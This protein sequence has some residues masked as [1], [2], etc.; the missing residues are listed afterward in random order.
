MFPFSPGVYGREVIRDVTTT[1]QVGFTGGAVITAKKGPLAPTRVTER[2]F[3]NLY[4]KPSMDTPSMLAV[5]R[6]LRR[7]GSSAVIKRVIVDATP[8]IGEIENDDDSIFLTIKAANPGVWG[9]GISITFDKDEDV[10]G[11]YT[12]VVKYNSEE[13]ERY[14]VSFNENDVD[15]FGQ[16]RYIESR[17]NGRSRYIEVEHSGENVP[18]FA[19]EGLEVLALDGGTDDT[20]PVSDVEVIAGLDEFRNKEQIQIDYLMNAG[21][22]SAAVHAAIV[23]VAEHRK[24]CVAV[25]D[26]PNDTDV[27]SLV[28]FRKV[29]SNIN[30]S[31]AAYYAGWLK[32]IDPTSGREVE[33]PPSGDVA[34]VYARSQQDAAIWDAPAGLRRGVIGDVIG[35]N[36]VFSED[37]RTTL[38]KA[39]INPIQVFEGEGVVVWGQKTATAVASSVDRL[40]VRFLLNYVRNTAVASLK[41]F[42]FQAN[43]EFTRSSIH[44]LLEN[45]LD[46][47]QANGGIYGKYIDVSTDINTPEV[48]QGNQL[49]VHIYLQP[50]RTGEF[51]QVDTITVPLSEEL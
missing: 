9:N 11:V 49:L 37:D 26:M 18:P 47:V 48:I 42:V 44:S 30:S 19:A 50:T 40:N 24:D 16:S 46:G 25:L 28:E 22:V 31:F 13:V 35:M 20:T 51:I 29:T 3:Y 41:P 33:I 5:A 14:S 15:G 39:G 17:V 2:E 34:A 10:D 6:F 4:G 27:N 7:S 38:Y 43:T 12:L 8:A 21:W 1:P 23:S 36:K 32:V 45:F